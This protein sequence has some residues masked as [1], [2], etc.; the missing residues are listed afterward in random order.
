MQDGFSSP[1]PCPTLPRLKE[2]IHMR[3]LHAIIHDIVHLP[4]LQPKFPPLPSPPQA[5]HARPRRAVQPT[6]K[7]PLPNHAG[8]NLRFHPPP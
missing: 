7:L 1:L 3:R 8:V 2:T 6:L 4:I 5:F